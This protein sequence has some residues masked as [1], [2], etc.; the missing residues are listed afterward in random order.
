MTHPFSNRPGRGFFGERTPFNKARAQRR[1]VALEAL[2]A[3]TLLA[4]NPLQGFL[5]GPQSGDPFTLAMTYLRN[6]GAEYGLTGSDVDR[7]VIS[8]MLPDLKTGTTRIYLQQGFD[9]I[10]VDNQRININ[11]SSKGEIINVGGGF[12]TSLGT[13][14]S[15][16]QP[17]APVLSATGAVLAAANFLG[18]KSN[19]P[20][21][22]VSA[23][24]TADRTTIVSAPGLS[25]QATKMRLEYLAAPDGAVNLTWQLD[26]DVPGQNNWWEMNVDTTTGEVLRQFNYT[27]E[28]SYNVFQ[29]PLMDPNDGGRTV[30]TDPADPTASPFGWHDTNGQT[31]AEST[32][33]KGNNVNAYEDSGNN[34]APGFQ[35][36]GG[37]GLNFNFE[38]DLTKAPSTYQAASVTNLFYTVNVLHDVLYNYGFDEVSGNFQV[39][40]YGNG[41]LGND[42]VLAEAQDGSGT[43]NANFST[44]PDGQ[45]GRMQ[46]Y[47]G[48]TVTP[49][50]DGSL[51]N[52]VVSHEMGHGWSIRLTGGPADSGSLSQYQSRGMGEGYGDFLGLWSTLKEEYAKE[53]PRK[54]ADYLIPGYLPGGLRRF[55]YSYDMTINPLTAANFNVFTP[56]TSFYNTGELW[57]AVLY[58]MTWEL[59][60]RYGFDPNQATGSGGNNIAMQLVNTG[61][62]LQPSN[63]TVKEARDGILAADQLIYGGA[64]QAA[65]WK[66]F[67]RRGM[68]LNFDAG[69]NTDRD[70][71]KPDFT[72]PVFVKAIFVKP[73]G[74]EE[75]KTST[76]KLGQIDD[77]AGINSPADYDVQISWG[78]GSPNTTGTV[79]MINPNL[80]DIR[81]THEYKEGGNYNIGIFVQKTGGRGQASATGSLTAKDL[82]I[83]ATSVP[84][85]VP[86]EGEPYTGVIGTFFDTDTDPIGPESYSVTVQWG[87]DGTQT[88]GIVE[89]D[90]AAGFNR[91]KVRG[92]HV[93]G[94]GNSAVVMNVVGPGLGTASSQTQV[95][96]PDS[97]L[98][99]EAFD[100]SPTEGKSFN[101]PLIAFKDKDK[102][103]PPAS[104]YFATIKWGDGTQSSG[105]IVADPLEPRF[106]VVGDHKYDWRSTP[107]D[108]EV[109]VGN[110]TGNETTSAKGKATVSDAPLSGNGFNYTI[111]AG[112]NLT[113]FFGVFTD[114]DTRVQ[115]VSHY[116]AVIDWDLD[117][118]DNSDNSVGQIVVNSDGG[119]L[120]K[121]THAYGVAK[122]YRYGITVANAPAT[123]TAMLTG[124][125]TVTPSPLT[126]DVVTTA[127][128]VE[129]Q[130]IDEVIARFTT[131]NTL[132]KAGD[133]FATINWG[134]NTTTT[135]PAAKIEKVADGEFAVYGGKK[136]Y[137]QPGTYDVTVFVTTTGAQAGD[138][139]KITVLDAPLQ[140]TGKVLPQVRSK[141]LVSDL[142]VASFSD[143]DSS[144]TL[145]D[146]SATINWGDSTSPTQGTIV[147]DGK[148]G[149]NVVASHAFAKG[150][151]YPITT[152]I[153]SRLG[154]TT[155]AIGTANVVAKL[156]DLT[157]ALAAASGTG[158]QQGVTKSAS[159]VLAGTAEPG[160]TVSLFANRPGEAQTLIGKAIADLAGNWTATSNTLVDGSYTV[161]ASAVDA[162][163]EVSSTSTTLHGA[164]KPLVVDSSGPRVSQ[165]LVQP[166]TGQIQV[167]L[168][169]DGS[170]LAEA[171]L[172]RAS[173]YSLILVNETSQKV[174]KA[175][176]VKTNGAD[177]ATITFR[178]LKNL[179]TG[180]YV[181]QI[182]AKGLTDVAGN[183]LDERYFIPFP[184]IYQKSGQ[185]YV[186]QF[187][188]NGSSASGLRQY[189]PPPEIEAARK[190][191]RLVNGR[192][193][194]ARQLI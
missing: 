160:A 75:N 83:E 88:A 7:F 152:K 16:A 53:T 24:N 158:Y 167:A 189:V 194:P 80:F 52:M 172:R 140:S 57:A 112:Q 34:N 12:S 79:V 145:G 47:I 78:D 101:T 143:T 11:V 48:T 178:G 36:D 120:V 183:I 117:S 45:S 151:Q 38:M 37:S 40:N 104:N 20:P 2:E 49:N 165:V 55:P 46:M 162:L 39:N 109:I 164:S 33:T 138:A 179:G 182:S 25:R 175:A 113:K 118:S 92:S 127:T 58:D 68:G 142:L 161:S 72:E 149:F 3:R 107:Y 106:F 105:T 129:T 63:P 108:F 82:P 157:G 15:A 177:A 41:G 126:V 1:K 137:D 89:A 96:V 91:F 166:K 119:Y 6:N 19:Q 74:V 59:I 42:P 95:D 150:G 154:S 30:A 159:P 69:Q 139:G 125:I 85:S 14:P 67:A 94:G 81:G 70:F 97:K 4:Y 122:T 100:I 87:D 147:P 10:R 56:D 54:V 144:P 180:S 124:R 130:A 21:I 86:G 98:E 191:R 192:L 18:L 163:G 184:G 176:T 171:A 60:G 22:I 31:G 62:K 135:S 73:T 187:D 134:D 181:I 131:S 174:L 23:E 103:K 43:D 156:F 173:N 188:S 102:R 65:I 186:A 26:L 90:P 9:G 193:R 185:N 32:L 35:P 169:D 8:D 27:N 61:M 29:L 93:F 110:F 5:T 116:Q 44:P 133:F 190:F 84:I 77:Q 132:A 141:T 17:P 114:A 146:F 148:G 111:G 50:H 99:S 123:S 128:P 170:G 66:V 71:P 76:F 153:T 51:D 13:L 28:A 168:V 121:A 64:N 115:P 136:V 155:T